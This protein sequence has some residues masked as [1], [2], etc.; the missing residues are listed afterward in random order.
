[1][2]RATR[3]VAL[4]LVAV[5]GIYYIVTAGILLSGRHDW[6]DQAYIANVAVPTSLECE[7][8]ETIFWVGVDTLGCVHAGL[9]HEHE[10]GG[11]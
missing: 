1:M 8:D 7:E 10:G 6:H 2:S 4:T 3:T 5:L 11:E 9:V